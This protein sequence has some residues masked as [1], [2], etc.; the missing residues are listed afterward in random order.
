MPPGIV[1]NLLGNLFSHVI[2]GQENT[3]QFEVRIQSF[4]YK[5]RKTQELDKGFIR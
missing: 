4:L 1:S 2:H 3:C 5:T